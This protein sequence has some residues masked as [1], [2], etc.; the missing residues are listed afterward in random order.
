MFTLVRTQVPGQRVTGRLALLALAAA[1]GLAALLPGTARADDDLVRVI[2]QSADVVFRGGD[3]Y[4]RHG[5]YGHGDRLI[6][7][8]DGYGRP[9]YY[10][11]VPRDYYGSR[12][13]EGPPYGNAHGYWRQHRPDMQRRVTCDRQGRCVSRYYDPR[14]DRRHDGHRD[15]WRRDYNQHP[16]RTRFGDQDRYRDR[17]GYWD[18]RR[19]RSHGD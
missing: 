18:G 2:V 1:L 11:I 12:Y 7:T 6:V 19:W 14:Y 4:Y 3:A 13:R 8:R 5:T 15:G 17:Y 10:R 16:Y 9:V